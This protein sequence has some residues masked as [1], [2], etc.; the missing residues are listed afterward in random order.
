MNSITANNFSRALS[1]MVSGPALSRAF[2]AS[3]P[4]ISHAPIWQFKVEEDLNVPLKTF[5]LENKKVFKSL[6][7]DLYDVRREQIDFLQGHLPGHAQKINSISKGYFVGT[8]PRS[9][10]DPFCSAL[11]KSE[12][13]VFEQIKPYRFRA[14]SRFEIA[15][16]QI[17]RIATGDF[18]QTLAAIE[19]EKELDWR[20]QPRVFSPLENKH[21][22]PTLKATLLGI[23]KQLQKWDPKIQSFDITVHH[24]RILTAQDRIRSNSPEGIH[25]DGYPYLATALVVEKENISGGVSEIFDDDKKTLIFK[26]T[27]GI[28]EGILQPDRGTKLWHWVTSTEPTDPKKIGVRSI[29]GFDIDVV[30]EKP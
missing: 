4:Q 19:D 24:V 7:P 17:T 13:A 18:I 23:A 20:K 9:A 29:I 12:R 14:V 11:S 21:V 1:G 30:K 25:Q 27:L 5:A 28:G 10:I 22:T 3:W 26:T 2:H 15:Q 6:P 8:L 16:D